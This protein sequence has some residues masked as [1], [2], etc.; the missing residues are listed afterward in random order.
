MSHV[1]SPASVA[2]PDEVVAEAPAGRRSGM[3]EVDLEDPRIDAV[4]EE[5]KRRGTVLDATLKVGFFREER[6]AARDSLATPPAE[7]TVQ[8]PEGPPPDPRRPRGTGCR[9]AGAPRRTGLPPRAGGHAHGRGHP[10]RDPQ[11]RAGARA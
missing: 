1:C 7:R 9:V 10:G 8:T 2:I 3:V 11:R 5:M 4:L 6:M